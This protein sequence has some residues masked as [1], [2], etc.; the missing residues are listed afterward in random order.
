MY[1]NSMILQFAPSPWVDR[2]AIF[3]CQYFIVINR[4]LN[5]KHKPLI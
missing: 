4:E 1:I 5:Q 3:L 2:V